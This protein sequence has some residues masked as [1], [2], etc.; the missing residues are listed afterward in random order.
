MT[1]NEDLLEGPGGVAAEEPLDGGDEDVE[2]G[3]LHGTLTP[4][5]SG[6]QVMAREV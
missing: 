6:D 2:P 1:A 3:R 4:G 5:L